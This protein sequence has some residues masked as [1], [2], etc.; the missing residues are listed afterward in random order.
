MR[1]RKGIMNKDELFLS[2]FTRNSEWMKL[3]RV[4]LKTHHECVICGAQ[5]RLEA[6]HIK[7]YFVFP[8]LELVESNLVTLCAP[9]HFTF[10]HLGSWKSWNP[11]L[12]EDVKIWKEKML[13]RPKWMPFLTV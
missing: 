10:G 8:E 5:K 12:V 13:N 3:R 1:D 4:F 11:A 7:P 9:D 6:H 2:T